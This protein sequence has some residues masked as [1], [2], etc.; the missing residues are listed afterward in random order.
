MDDETQGNP[1]A[2]R[3]PRSLRGPGAVRAVTADR[4]VPGDRAV[5]GDR[6]I[7]GGAAGL[8]GDSG[9]DG[10]HL[11]T[12]DHES[13]SLRYSQEVTSP[14]DEP[15]RP[16]RSLVTTSHEVI[17][18]WAEERG[19]VPA[20]VGGTE[21]GDHLGVLRFDFGGH[22]DRLQPV[23]WDEWFHAF[24]VRGLNFVYQERRKDG[25]RSNFFRL[26]NPDPSSD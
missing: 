4:A 6:A 20:T 21:H 23:P 15:E 24:D 5:A 8:P 13:S 7:R 19:A 25:H 17:R 18:R 10:G 3:R 22:A 9:P 14:A 12:G 26:T 16:G 2:G 1:G 11:R